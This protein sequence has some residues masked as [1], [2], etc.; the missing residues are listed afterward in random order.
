MFAK[1]GTLVLVLLVQSALSLRAAPAAH[2]QPGSDVREAKFP[3]LWAAG[4]LAGGLAYINDR[5]TCVN[6]LGAEG[7]C[8]KKCKDMGRCYG[9]C[10]S[11][12]CI[13]VTRRAGCPRGNSVCQR[14][15]PA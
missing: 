12:A 14:E 15:C 13:C 3:W 7:R 1:A 2:A 9:A 6:P 10:D 8:L 5:T 4:A 11:L